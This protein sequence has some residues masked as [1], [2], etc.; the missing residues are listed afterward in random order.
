MSTDPRVLYVII[1]VRVGLYRP[2]VIGKIT[3]LA[4]KTP[5]LTQK[6]SV[7]TIRFYSGIE[8]NTSHVWTLGRL[9]MKIYRYMTAGQKHSFSFMS[10]HFHT[11][12]TSCD[13]SLIE[14][15]RRHWGGCLF[16]HQAICYSVC[17]GSM[18][19]KLPHGVCGLTESN[20]LRCIVRKIIFIIHIIYIYVL[21]FEWT[22][23]LC[24]SV[25]SKCFQSYA[26]VNLV[27]VV[28]ASLHS[29]DSVVIGDR[30][31]SA[32]LLAFTVVLSEPCQIC[33]VYYYYDVRT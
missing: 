22:L 29:Y 20:T 13:I 26:S 17:W 1:T 2:K 19:N 27:Y 25:G 5:N 31:L 6:P 33:F 28:H 14:K 12:Q 10:S 30:T 32:E 9:I 7:L 18:Q 4:T 21:L 24:F 23:N 11:F 15:D 16:P 8:N 3:H